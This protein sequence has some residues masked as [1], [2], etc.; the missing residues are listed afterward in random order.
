VSLDQQMK[1]L[2]CSCRS[3]RV[4][5]G[6]ASGKSRLFAAGVVALLLGLALPAVTLAQPMGMP[7]GPNGMPDLRL[8]NG[9]SRPDPSDPVG[10]VTVR[11][12]RKTFANP[13][14]GLD[15]TL[16]GKNEGGDVRKRTTK[17]NDQGR[18]VFD[19]VAPGSSVT[20][21]V[22]VDGERLLSEPFVQPSASGVRTLLVAGLGAAPAGEAGN[23][24][25]GAASSGEGGESSGAGFTLGVTTGVVRLDPTLPAKTLVVKAFDREGRP[26]AGQLI[27]LGQVS[28]A[29]GSQVHLLR[30]TTKADGVATFKDLP[31]GPQTGYAAVMGREGM[32]IG[33]EA[34]ALPET[35]GVVVELK[36]LGRTADPSVI[37]IGEGARIVLEVNEDAVQ[38]LEFLPLVNNGSQIFDGEPG[39]FAI[40]LPR[41]FVSAEGAEGDTPIEVRKGF[42]VS[43]HVTVPPGPPPAARQGHAPNEVRFGFALPFH[44]SSLTIEQP[45]PAGLGPFSFIAQKVGNID[46]ESAV[47]EGKRSE[48]QL[49]TQMFLI[50]P[51]AAIGR[52]GSLRV[53]VT[54][55][56]A[57]DRTGRNVAAVLVAALL[58]GTVALSW[59]RGGKGP[60]RGEATLEEKL[61]ADREQLF[62]QLLAVERKKE[63]GSESPQDVA[64]RRDLVTKLEDVLRALTAPAPGPKAHPKA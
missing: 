1:K 24:P 48:K 26:L 61:T 23:A 28:S 51:G 20:L 60:A 50:W 37:S 6:H 31:T 54:G 3:S 11:V 18:A 58:L 7:T 12:V 14:S 15:V 47:F 16:L 30:E 13:A 41:E 33:S 45:L 25:R 22:T 9:K 4:R 32:R 53:H 10:Q 62:E 34:F 17:T 39:G 21:E 59:R 44:G 64:L 56:P 43:A 55:L 29:A 19:S 63:T 57:H 38:V 49:G 8:M 35:G 40:P 36:V 52:G 2:P 46:V 5:S 42:G 27:E